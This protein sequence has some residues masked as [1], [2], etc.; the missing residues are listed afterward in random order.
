MSPNIRC[1]VSRIN[2]GKGEFVTKTGYTLWSPRHWLASSS[3]AL[4]AKLAVS[5]ENNQFGLS[6]P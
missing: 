6:Q 4:A 3:A 2:F 1:P 5:G